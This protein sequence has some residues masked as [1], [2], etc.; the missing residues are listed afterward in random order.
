MKHR[1]AELEERLAQLAVD[2]EVARA[3]HAAALSRWDGERELYAHGMRDAQMERERWGRVEA[4]LARLQP[5]L[6]MEAALPLK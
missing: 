6:A 4:M 5:Q 2:L 1:H 3:D